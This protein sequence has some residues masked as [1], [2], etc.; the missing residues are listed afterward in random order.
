VVFDAAAGQLSCDFVGN[1]DD[2]QAYLKN[3]A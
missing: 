2:V 3:R 1:H